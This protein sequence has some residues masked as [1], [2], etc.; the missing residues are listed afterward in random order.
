MEAPFL[1]DCYKCHADRRA[2]ACVDFDEDEQGVSDLGNTPLSWS[3]AHLVSNFLLM[4]THGYIVGKIYG[5]S[6]E[7]SERSVAAFECL[8]PAWIRRRRRASD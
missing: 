1:R 4:S 8:V 2:F 5:E 3:W 6:V 7:S